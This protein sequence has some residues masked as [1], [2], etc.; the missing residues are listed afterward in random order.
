LGAGHAGSL[1]LPGSSPLHR[2]PAPCKLVAAVG[3]VVAVVATPREALWAFAAHAAVVVGLARLGR[4]PLGV[5]VRRL[6]LEVPFLAFAA[7]LPFLARGERVDVGPV[8][9]S[10]DGLWGAWNILAKGSLGLATTVVLASTTELSDVVRGLER[11]RVPR[12][13]TSVAGFMVRYADVIVGEMARMRIARQSRGHDPRWL[14]QA[15]AVAHSAGALFVRSY[16][17]GERVHLAMLSRG[18]SGGMPV[19]GEDRVPAR[20]W[21]AALAL[22]CAGAAVA[23]AAWAGR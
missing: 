22:P 16:E 23:L 1:Y 17:R 6:A 18:Y 21:A 2:L 5:L 7:L 11:L 9:L 20:A 10:V 8:A 3:F 19:L 12:A 4:L 14:W 13:L 15:R